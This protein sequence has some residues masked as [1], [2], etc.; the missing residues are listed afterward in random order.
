MDFKRLAN[1]L[2]LVVLL[3][4]VVPFVI[5]AAPGVIGAE[6]SFVVLTG[7]MAPAIDPGDVVIVGERDPSS[8]QEGDV[9]TFVRGDAE[10]PVTHR[11]VGVE[12][13]D[14]G[15]AFETKGDA[16]A[17]VDASPVP[18]SNVL[19]VVILTIPYIG[20]VVQ[21]TDGPVGFAL[22]VIVPLALLVA[23]E[24]WTLFNSSRATAGQDRE[25]AGE[26]EPAADAD[27]ESATVDEPGTVT[28]SASELGLSSGVLALVTPYTIYVALDLRTALSISVAF[29]A[30]FSLLAVGGLWLSARYAG[31]RAGDGDGDARATDDTSESD[32]PTPSEGDSDATEPTSRSHDGFEEFEPAIESTEPATDGGRSEGEHE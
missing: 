2:G 17:E 18:A 16:N 26:P 13:G 12:E 6:Y 27:T 25:S 32:D 4:L 10:T 21:A 31:A 29:A 7:S 9:I 8:I 19:G 11:V 20:Y 1:V 3:A 5:Y 22:L 30:T 15:V 28:F 14:A 23:S 24:L